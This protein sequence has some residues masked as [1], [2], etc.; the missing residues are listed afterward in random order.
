MEA[1]RAKVTLLANVAL[2]LEYE[3]ACGRPEHV[4][5]SGLKTDEVQIFV[6]AVIAMA[7]P[8]GSHYMWRPMLRDPGDELVLEAAVNGGA[9]AIVTYNQR[10][11]GTAP[12]Q[13]GV[14]VLTP[15]IVLR[16]IRK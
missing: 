16:R 3:A 14:E 5:A 12:A 7:E 6:D 11:F 9:E 2:V 13:F 10:D 1:R 4:M 8:V 15:N